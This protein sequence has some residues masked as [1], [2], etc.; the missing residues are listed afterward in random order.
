M[1]QLAIIVA[2]NMVWPA[3]KD[4]PRAFYVISALLIVY[5][6]VLLAWKSKLWPVFLYGAL[7]AL[8]TAGCGAFFEADGSRFVC[9]SGTGAPVSLISGLGAL[10][11]IG[12]MLARGKK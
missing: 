9:D 6:C 8:M 11:L 3:F 7:M 2:A 1:W 10:L 5:L 12:Y 4:G